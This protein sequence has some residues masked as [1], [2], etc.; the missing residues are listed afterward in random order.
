MCIP[1]DELND[2][3][4]ATITAIFED[5]ARSDI[6][7]SDILTLFEALSNN[8]LKADGFIY[9]SLSDATGGVGIFPCPLGQEYFGRHM[10]GNLREYLRGV[11]VE[12]K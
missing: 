10:V 5:P 11:G 1:F 2:D 8:I 7:W 9:V 3:H 4:Q 6:L 12:P